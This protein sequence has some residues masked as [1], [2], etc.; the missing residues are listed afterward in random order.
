MK[1][2]PMTCDRFH[3]WTPIVI[4][5]LLLLPM[6]AVGRMPPP[7]GLLTVAVLAGVV[8]ILGIATLLAPRIAPAGWPWALRNT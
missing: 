2:F 5:P 1:L 8:S 3:A 7:A 4:G 6:F